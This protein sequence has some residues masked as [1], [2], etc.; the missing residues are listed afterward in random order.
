MS[1]DTLAY[2]HTL[3]TTASTMASFVAPTSSLA[4]SAR[5]L[6]WMLTAIAVSRMGGKTYRAA[7]RVHRALYRS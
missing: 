6:H 4:V 3:A 7:R 2:V 5:T 1:R